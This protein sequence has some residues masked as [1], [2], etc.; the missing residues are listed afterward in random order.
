[1]KNLYPIK[2]EPIIKE[3][4]WGGDKLVKFYLKDYGAGKAVGESWEI[5]SINDNVSVI[6]NGFL[7]GNNIEELL[8]A[9][10][11]DVTGDKIYEKFGNIFPLLIKYLDINEKLSIQVHPNNKIAE[12]R[13]S[14]FGKTECWYIIDAEPNAKIYCGLKRDTTKEEFTDLCKNEKLEEILNV[15]YP[16]KGDTLFIEPGTLH[17]A[18]GG[19]LLAEIQQVSDITYRVYDWGRENDPISK[20]EM[21][22]ELAL[23]CINYNELN[24]DEKVYKKAIKT[25][26]DKIILNDSEFFKIEKILLKGR[27]KISTSESDTFVI[28]MCVEGDALLT[29]SLGAEAITAGETILIPAQMEDFYLENLTEGTILL[30]VT[31]K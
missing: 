17:S 6:T 12:E 15:I 13:H 5:S 27:K 21:H 28:Y 26:S 19:L 14:S 1:M 10:M 3:R 18:T 30:E 31:G 23:D 4:V 2:F 25:D 7:Q 11:G 9:Y 8:E 29:Y 20:R 24:L 22:L 16:Q